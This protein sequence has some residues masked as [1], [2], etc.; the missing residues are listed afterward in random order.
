MSLNEINA[1]LIEAGFVVPAAGPRYLTH[2]EIGAFADALR[3][4]LG[5]TQTQVAD[6]ISRLRGKPI[7]QQ[8]VCKGLAGSSS[9]IKPILLWLEAR[10][11]T[12]V[13]FERDEQGEPVW[14]VKLFIAPETQ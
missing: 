8:A 1:R 13:Q 6:E 14:R 5:L 7:S 11:P 12:P 4:L 10:W 2:A 3:R 9:C